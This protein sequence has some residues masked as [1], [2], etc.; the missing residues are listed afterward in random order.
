MY[1]KTN[2][3]VEVIS[4]EDKLPRDKYKPRKVLV[5]EDERDIRDLVTAR[6]WNPAVAA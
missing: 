6:A 2:D 3:L 4:G 5:I 1:L